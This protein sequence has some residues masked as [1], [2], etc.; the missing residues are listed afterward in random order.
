MQK[1]ATTPSARE[2]EIVEKAYAYVLAHGLSD[3]SLRPLAAGIGSSP[4]V[5]LFLFGSKEGVIRRLLV[6]A[7][8]DELESLAGLE[9]S[10]DLPETVERVWTWLADPAHE[11]V[12]RLW[13]EAY[14]RSVSGDGPWGDFAATTVADWLDLLARAQPAAQ[15][16]TPGAEAARTLALAVLRGALLDLLATGDRPRADAAVAAF[17]VGIRPAP[18][19]TRA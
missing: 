12:L 14:G 1:D 18:G 5:L 13:A 11:P 17:L 8:Q 3:L 4:R 10:G 9:V 2:Q 7:R 16:A 6:R 15:R 19:G